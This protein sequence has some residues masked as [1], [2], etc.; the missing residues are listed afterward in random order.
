MENKT[1]YSVQIG[2]EKDPDVL[3]NEKFSTIDEAR[4]R[5]EIVSIGL[6]DQWIKKTKAG[7]SRDECLCCDLIEYE[8][9][10]N[11]DTINRK[12]IHCR[13]VGRKTDSEF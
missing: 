8:I 2:W 6:K 9:D 1:V 3:T 11:G 5:F 12:M 7:H 13:I 10:G 4:L